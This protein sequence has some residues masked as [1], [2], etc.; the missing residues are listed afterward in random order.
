MLNKHEG[1]EDEG[2]SDEYHC[3]EAEPMYVWFIGDEG[4]VDCPADHG[5]K[6]QQVTYV[7]FEGR[8]KL[9][10]AFADNIE[11]PYH[12]NEDGEGLR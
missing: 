11:D 5:G 4:G 9:D 12:G 1:G 6:Y 2:G 3:G 10:I 7:E 8:E